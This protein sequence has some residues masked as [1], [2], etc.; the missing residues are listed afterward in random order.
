M[1]WP[2]TY[3]PFWWTLS[4]Y[5]R[6][7]IKWKSQ[8]AW[9][10][11]FKNM[12][13]FSYYIKYRKFC[14][15]LVGHFVEHKTSWYFWRLFA[16]QTNWNSMEVDIFW[17][18][19]SHLVFKLYIHKNLWNFFEILYWLKAL[20]CRGFR[21]L[22]D[23]VSKNVPSFGIII[24]GYCSFKKKLHFLREQLL[25]MWVQKNIRYL[26]SIISK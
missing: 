7:F 22:Y 20:H 14:S 8:F 3:F 24:Y 21:H 26:D 4:Y 10:E 23:T 6:A 18:L 2:H 5:S 11:K 12:Y 19:W 13:R 17:K 16:F 15:I 9:N 25:I 1:F